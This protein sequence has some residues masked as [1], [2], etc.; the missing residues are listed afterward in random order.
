MEKFTFDL[1][2]FKE[3]GARI[4]RSY[5]CDGSM[6]RFEILAPEPA[7]IRKREAENSAKIMGAGQWE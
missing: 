6:G 4:L 2:K 7:R 1:A 5:F 3:K